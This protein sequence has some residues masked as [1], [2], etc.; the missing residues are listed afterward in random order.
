MDPVPET[1]EI[2]TS[3]SKFL[4]SQAQENFMHREAKQILVSDDVMQPQPVDSMTHDQMMIA[5]G[6]FIPAFG[7]NKHIG[8]RWFGVHDTQKTDLEKVDDSHR[9]YSKEAMT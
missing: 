5:P 2:A 8:T 3:L 6:R 7:I 9:L 4:F 1:V